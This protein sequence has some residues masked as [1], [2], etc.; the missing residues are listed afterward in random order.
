MLKR[1]FNLSMLL[2]NPKTPLAGRGILVTR[3]AHQAVGLVEKIEQAGAMVFSCPAIEIVPPGNPDA[4]DEQ[5]QQLDSFD[6]LIF[7]SA[8]AAR[9]GI[10]MIEKNHQMPKQIAIAAVGQATTRMVEELGYQVAILPQQRF[11]SEGLLATPQLQQV[12][13]KRVLIVRG[14]GGREL[15][16]SRLRE[17]GA[18]VHYAEAYRRTIPAVDTAPILKA[19]QQ[20]QIDAAIVTS[21][22]GLDNLISL[23]GPAGHA[24]LLNTPLVVISQRTAE[25][26]QE[27]G[28]LH[29]VLLTQNPS[30]P[31]ILDTLTSYFVAESNK[32][33]ALEQQSSTL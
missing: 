25:V 7:I 27:R 18:T 15:L 21:N 2:Q 33:E 22:Q 32:G 12:A 5:F 19:W 26:A 1:S 4:A 3:P 28:F 17:R 29:S 31:A 20:Q 30:D 11:D 24:Y 10:G 16:A 14:E 23:L 6:I 8:N 9:I 13:G